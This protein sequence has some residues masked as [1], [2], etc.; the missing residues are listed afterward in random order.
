[1][2][3]ILHP[4]SVAII[5]A[6]DDGTKTTGRPLRFL[7]QAKFAGRVYPVNPNRDTVQGER[8]WP[9]VD[10]LPEVPEHAY[11]VTP[12]D[13]ALQAVEQCGKRG[14][15]VATVL[16]DGF[17]EAGEAGLARERALRGI[18]AATGIRVIGP[19]SLGVANLHEG[20]MLTANAAFAE[21]EMPRGSIFVASQSGTMIGSILSRGKARGIGFAGLVSVGN[22]VDLGAGEIC[23]STLDDASVTGY[24]LFLE[25]LRHADAL[26]RFALA[27]VERGK[28][29][30]AYKLGR[31]AAGA[32]LSVSH[33]G[34]LA[35]EDDVA[36]AFFRES[37]IARVH[38]LD[39]LIEALPLVARIPIRSGGKPRVKVITTTGGGA[40]M[41]VDQLGVRGIEV[42]EMIDLTLAGTRYDVMKAALD[43]ELASPEVDLVIAVP[44]SSARYEPQ[45]A[46]KP[47]IDCAASGKP[48]AAFVVPDAPEA[49]AMLS[50]AGVP[51]FRTPEACA[52]AVAAAFSRHACV[53]RH[54]AGPAERGTPSGSRDPCLRRDDSSRVLDEMASY[55]RLARIG[56]RHA[57]A[58]AIDESLRHALQYPLAV[59]ALSAAIPHKSDAGGVVLDVAS[60]E[61]LR[62]AVNRI[63]AATRADRF[64][65][66]QMVRGAGEV[67][68]GY[69]VDAQVGPIV[70]LAAGGVLAEVHRD[71]SI[72]LAPVDIESAREMIEE[73]A[74][75]KA[76]RGYRGRARGDL[77][78]LATAVVAMSRLAEDA[79]VIEAEI[80]PLIVM[81]EGRG[82]VAVDALVRVMT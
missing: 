35:G 41:V 67:L 52:D 53:G 60:A 12:A 14:V 21:P 28:P 33:T 54:P 18:V 30:V 73:V 4:A 48:I 55:E 31:S 3:Q 13:A 62:T 7:R 65:V 44:G 15:R 1:M 20:L 17:S 68:L 43:R 16:A 37:G 75:F 50:V 26:R 64:L 58:Q 74:A 56:V 82:I 8:A 42:A 2:R 70:M 10:A 69:M 79:T 57:P 45:L 39:G 40:A 76:L 71:R 59:K 23:A 36:D 9:S 29:V 34:A 11:V 6:S 25:T 72:R 80:N 81:E 77:E 51:N 66:Q 24:L 19:S 61:E 22:E 32:R 27:A 5:G 49:L 46:V 47:V 63:K 78:A 38:T